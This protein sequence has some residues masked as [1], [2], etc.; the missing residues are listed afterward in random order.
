MSRL[1]TELAATGAGYLLGSIPVGLLVG[2]AWRGRDVRETGSGSSGTTNVLRLAGPGAAAVTFALDV[3]KGSAGVGAARALGASP[4][5]QVAAGLA[6]CVGHSWPL[7]AG[8]RGGKSVATALGALIP[9][10]PPASACAVT[11]GLCALFATRTVSVASLA[12]ATSATVAC[13]VRARSGGPA[14]PLVFAGLA[15]ALVAVRHTENLRRIVGGTE[16]R[17]GLARLPH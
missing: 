5:G 7:F 9:M 12:A 10:S 16:P 15:S 2:R 11:G 8:F 13:G 14:A 6:A 17:L 4:A 3:A 1:R